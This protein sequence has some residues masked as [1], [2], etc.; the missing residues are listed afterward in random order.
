MSEKV[1]SAK[2]KLVITKS[3][4]SLNVSLTSLRFFKVSL[5]IAADLLTL[6]SS[7]NL[8]ERAE[9]EE[10]PLMTQ[11]EIEELKWSQLQ[12]AGQSFQTIKQVNV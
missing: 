8:Q 9:V 10:L 6:S 1:L 5:T 12:T 4:L 7:P 3:L 2:I 11:T